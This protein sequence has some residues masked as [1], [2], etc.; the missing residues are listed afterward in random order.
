MLL[1]FEKNIFAC[2]IIPKHTFY[3]QIIVL[4]SQIYICLAFIMQ[5]INLC[6]KQKP[7]QIINN[8]RRHAS[9]F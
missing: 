4:S 8:S 9:F 3:T 2:Y 5:K 7:V 6:N 1:L